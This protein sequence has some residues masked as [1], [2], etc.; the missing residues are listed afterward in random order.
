MRTLLFFICAGAALAFRHLPPVPSSCTAA[1]RKSVCGPRWSTDEPAE[2]SVQNAQLKADI[3]RFKK[4]SASSPREGSGGAM[5]QTL[6]GLSLVL[7]VNFVVIFL[8]FLWFLWGVFSLYALKDDSVIILVKASFDP[9]ILPLLS[10]HMGL[11][12][13]SAGLE[14]VAGS[15][16]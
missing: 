6:K 10:T 5:Q 16:K 2:E 3:E 12:F 15:N 4:A 9:F 8:L 11:T 1:A 13:L 7:G 14:R